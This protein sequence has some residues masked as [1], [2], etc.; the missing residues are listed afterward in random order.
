MSGMA[1]L[2]QVN[3][4]PIPRTPLIGRERDAAAVSELLRRDDVPLVTLT[5]PGGVGKTRLA[6][7]VAANMNPEFADGVAIVSLAPVLDP[8]L[9]CSTVAQTL[10]V[11]ES[12]EE[13]LAGRLQA[14][15]QNKQ[16]LLVLDNF[17]QVVEAA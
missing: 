2:H 13:D 7:W 10:G 4:L 8:A 6:L 14:L 5:G 12:A 11:W 3:E 17:E 15:L 1:L 16:M 9:V